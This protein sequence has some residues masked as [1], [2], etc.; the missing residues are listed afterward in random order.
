MKGALLPREVLRFPIGVAAIALSW[1]LSAG[2][3]WCQGTITAVNLYKQTPSGGKQSAFIVEVQGTSLETAAEQP[4][5]LVFPSTGVTVTPLDHSATSIHAGI[6][7]PQNYEPV[8]IDLSYQNKTVPWSLTKT[9]CADDDIKKAFFYVPPSQAKEKYGTGV[10]KNFNVIQISIV[11]NCSLPVLIPLAGIYVATTADSC[12]G[13]SDCIYPFSLDHVTS[14]FSYDR[15]FSG[16]RAVYFNVLQGVATVGSSVE[17]FLA[18]GFTKG[19]SILGGSFTQASQT[20]WRDMTAEQLQNLTS[21]SYQAT[22]QVGPNG[23]SLQKFIFLPVQKASKTQNQQKQPQVS[24]AQ[25]WAEKKLILK[26]EVIPILT[27]SAS[28]TP[29]T[30]VAPPGT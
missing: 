21:Q 4:R 25:S 6:T 13:G 9:T 15:Q 5:L 14:I 7:A 26:V 1:L 12:P 23:G 3:V 27:P 24:F 19:V 11:N 28:T 17:P 10:G 16:R 2:L 20:I 18:S 8:E 22:E 30:P 29:T